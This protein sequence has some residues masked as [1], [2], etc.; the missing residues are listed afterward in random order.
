VDRIGVLRHKI[1]ELRWLAGSGCHA[2][3]GVNGGLD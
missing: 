3:A 1:V 2:I